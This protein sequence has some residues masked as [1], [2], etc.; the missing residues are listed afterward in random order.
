MPT[1][2][3]KPPPALPP[4]PTTLLSILTSTFTFHASPESFITSHILSHQAA[5]PDAITT[6]AVVRAKIL[7]RNVAVVSGY[8][9]VRAVLVADGGGGDGEEGQSGMDEAE[10]GSF[11]AAPAYND[12]MATFFPPPNLLLSD[13]IAHASLYRIWKARIAPLPSE[14]QPFVEKATR[15]HLRSLRAGTSIDLYATMKTLAWRLLL[16]TFL[17][18]RPDDP[19]FGTIERLQEDL[20][21]GQFSLFPVGLN[22]GVWHSP[23]KRGIDARV[24]LQGL[25]LERVRS[26]R[27]AKGVGAGA[28]PFECA[29]EGNVE[30]VAGHLLLFTSSLAAKGLASLLVACLLNLFLYRDAG[31]RGVFEE[32]ATVRDETERRRLLESMMLETERLSPPIVGVMRRCEKDFTFRRAADQADTLVPKGWDAWLYLVGAGRDPTKFGSSWNRFDHRRYLG[33]EVPL[34]MAFG[35][36]PKTCLGA[37]VVRSMVLA[38]LET[39]MA[40]GTELH[41]EVVAPG[42]R[43]WLGWDDS[44]TPE[45]W[46]ADMKQLPTQRP[47]KPTMVSF[48]SRSSEP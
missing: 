5:N 31:R 40:S 22:V 1:P 27:S 10:K 28:C 34:P 6:R 46:A 19:E 25:L 44:V 4:G 42:V 7:N 33:H 16:G 43:G 14:L 26:S 39:C 45:Q 23:R 30:D 48:F 41:G 3:P 15:T 37:G 20:L 21:R 38:V 24:R 36:G 29:E 11:T 13:G 2:K 18:L 8:D 9:D 47:A 12:L 35:V 17:G 32:L